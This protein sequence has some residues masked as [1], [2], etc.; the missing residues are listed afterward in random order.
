MTMPARTQDSGDPLDDKLVYIKSRLAAQCGGTLCV[1]VEVDYDPPGVNCRY[2]GS[3]PEPGS[4]FY[5]RKNVVVT[6]YASCDEEPSEEQPAGDGTSGEEQGNDQ[7]GDEQGNDQPGDE[8]PAEP[9]AGS[10][11]S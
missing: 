11:S 7:P 9:G 6:V 10:G 4:T 8:Q 2:Q 3:D 1:K 5:Y